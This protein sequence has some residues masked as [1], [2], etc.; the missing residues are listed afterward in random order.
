MDCDPPYDNVNITGT[1]IVSPNYPRGYPSN[2]Y[3]QVTLTFD[4]NVLI[5]F[6]WFLTEADFDVLELRDGNSSESSLITKLSG[7]HRRSAIQSTGRSMTLIFSSDEYPS[8]GGFKIL[9]DQG[10]YFTCQRGYL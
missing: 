6:Q 2:L 9:A 5:E 3:C 4:I 8:K 1:T 7:Y 10:I